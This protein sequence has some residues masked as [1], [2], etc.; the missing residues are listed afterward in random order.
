MAPTKPDGIVY[1]LPHQ[2][3]IHPE[4]ATTKLRI[5]Y[6]ASDR[7]GQNSKCLNDALHRGP[8]ILPNLV[9]L[10]LRFRI[11]PI[12]FTADIEKAFLQIALH[13]SDRD[14]TRFFW[15]KMLQKN[16]LKI[17]LLLTDLAEYH[18]GLSLHLF[19]CRLQYA[20]I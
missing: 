16:R 3:V 13:K 6:D 18:L 20:I 12:V 8:V 19:C 4:R 7:T 17:I 10:L 15:L 9:G 14:C 1:Y 5:V 11:P 2:P